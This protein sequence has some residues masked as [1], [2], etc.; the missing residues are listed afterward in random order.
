M[1]EDLSR[2]NCERILAEWD[3]GQQGL[4][5]LQGDIH[6][7]RATEPCQC[8]AQLAGNWG[9]L[10][11][12]ATRQWRGSVAPSGHGD[13]RPSAALPILEVEWLPRRAS[14]W[15]LTA[16]RLAEPVNITLKEY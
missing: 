1:V 12:A 15:H 14:A 9:P 16:S 8:K 11:R 13:K 2:R 3:Q 7:F 4:V 5:L 10:S 6:G